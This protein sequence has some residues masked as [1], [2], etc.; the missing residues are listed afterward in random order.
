MHKILMCNAKRT[1]QACFLDICPSQNVRTISASYP[2]WNSNALAITEDIRLQFCQQGRPRNFRHA[3]F[4]STR[5]TLIHAHECPARY[6]RRSSIDKSAS[7]VTAGA[8]AH[9][10]KMT[11]PASTSRYFCLYWGDSLRLT[12]QVLKAKARLDH[13]P[14]ANTPIKSRPW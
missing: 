8:K 11:D 13:T 12:R 14:A 5:P 10:R 6:R 3:S 1:E 7:R 2:T 4:E 9:Q